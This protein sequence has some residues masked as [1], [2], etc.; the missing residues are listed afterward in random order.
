MKKLVVIISLALLSAAVSAQNRSA[1]FVGAGAGF[2]VGF[3]GQKYENRVNSHSGSGLAGD[4]YLG[5]WLNKTIGVRAGYQGFNISDSY[6]FF[7]DFNY[8]YIHA[9]ALFRLTSSFV[10]YVHLGWQK[11]L[12]GSFG[13][14]AGLMLPIRLSEHVAIV[15][16]VRGTLS[17]NKL[18][19]I[20]SPGLAVTLSG[21]LGVVVSFG[22]S[23]KRQQN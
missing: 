5:A 2:N 23:G 18:Y 14:G 21:T 7:G 4:F 12:G 20:A 10:P 3:D 1:I 9:D 22:L 15:P 11:A 8:T 6:T 16:D 17:S 19:G 13:G